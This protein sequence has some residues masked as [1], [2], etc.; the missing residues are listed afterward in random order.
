METY[1]IL[2]EAFA[3]PR[4]PENGSQ[5]PL[6]ANS[7]RARPTNG[8]LTGAWSAPILPANRADPSG[9]AFE[10]LSGLLTST[11][12]LLII[13]AITL[14]ATSVFIGVLLNITGARARSLTSAELAQ[15][16]AAESFLRPEV[17][18][19]LSA[20]K[21]QA[22]DEPL[23]EKEIARNV[24]QRTII[25][26][27]PVLQSRPVALA[28]V[29][30]AEYQHIVEGADSPEVEFRFQRFLKSYVRRHTS[31]LSSS[32]DDTLTPA[33]IQTLQGYHHGGQG[34]HGW[35]K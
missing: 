33:E 17:R 23:S 29:L 22:V 3:G 2:R 31:P 21:L 4:L 27:A 7:G 16:Q 9:L 15:V 6:R 11:R 18:V 35:A 24:A 26:H 12:G 19:A 30:Y 32:P 20:A 1:G 13:A 5:G 8:T 14:V 25:V 10:G 34:D 28:I